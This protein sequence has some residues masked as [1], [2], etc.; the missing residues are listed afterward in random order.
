MPTLTAGI[1]DRLLRSGTSAEEADFEEDPLVQ[2]LDVQPPA[3][4]D[5]AAEAKTGRKHVLCVGPRVADY[6]LHPSGAPH[7]LAG[8]HGRVAATRLATGE[9]RG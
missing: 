4:D 2:L 3:E 9:L 5:D 1:V 7:M 8:V 6:Q